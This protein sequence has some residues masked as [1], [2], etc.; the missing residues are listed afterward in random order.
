MDSASIFFAFFKFLKS[1]ILLTENRTLML[2]E[3][4]QG[5]ALDRGQE[6]SNMFALP[7]NERKGEN[8]SSEITTENDEFNY[9]VLRFHFFW[10]IPSFYD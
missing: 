9:I 10:R 8:F 1:I 7:K 2:V 3:N 5:P 4:I 6:F